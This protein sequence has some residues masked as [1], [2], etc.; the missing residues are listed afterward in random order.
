[1]CFTHES[2]VTVIDISAFNS[3]IMV[4]AI[5]LD[6]FTLFYVNSHQTY[7]VNISKILNKAF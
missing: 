3:F 2:I 4:I 6:N 7:N 5:V 1:M